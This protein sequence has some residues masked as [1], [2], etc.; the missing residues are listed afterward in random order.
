MLLAIAA[1]TAAAW[2]LGWVQPLAAHAAGAPRVH[3][4]VI[5]HNQSDDPTLEPLRFADDDAIR[6][7]ELFQHVASTEELFVVPDE[8]TQRL[9]PHIA[10]RQPRRADILT[11]FEQLRERVRADRASGHSSA[12][13]VVYSGHGQT[14]R[15]GTGFVHL[16][17]GHLTTRDLYG[18]LFARL[19][20][21]PIVLIVD[22]CNAA[23][24]VQSRGGPE[25]RRVHRP[26]MRLEN[27]PH[28]G[29]VLSSSGAGEVHEWGRYLS[30]VFSHEVRSALVGPG[31]LD[32]DGR[33]T[34]VELATYVAAANEHVVN[35]EVRL[36][37][38][39]RPPLDFPELP[40]VDFAQARF[41]TQLIVESDGLQGYV[42]DEALVRH[43]DFHF[44]AGR[45]FSVALT[46]DD[47]RWFIVQ[48]DVEREIRPGAHGNIRVSSIPPREKTSLGKRGALGQYFEESLFQS[49]LGDGFTR[50]FLT[51]TYP[52]NIVVERYIDRPW[53]RS[54]LGWGL[55]G[56]S[57]ALAG[58]GAGFHAAALDFE[59]VASGAETASRRATANARVRDYGLTSQ[60]LYGVGAASLVGGI[61]AFV[62]DDRYDYERFDPGL[63]IDVGPGGIGIQGRF[64][65]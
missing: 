7:H 27:Y 63:I 42:V 62:L 15:D 56:A 20:G 65:D 41:P 46:H 38:Y 55:V 6:Y 9:Y 51:E 61:I 28:V 52:A 37:P 50:D 49:P 23:L 3:L 16:A 57:V 29:V 24:L 25:R 39:I 21:V 59:D 13:Y 22:A 1:A 2:L 64:G 12:V 30:G 60:V 58:T 33:V 34:F 5:G 31:D 36:N 43:A 32:G 19:E 45:Q 35:P 14:D 26:V 11:A 48:G 47:R 44:T 40:I 8:A 17:D 53:Y 18:E 4:L 10:P 54:G